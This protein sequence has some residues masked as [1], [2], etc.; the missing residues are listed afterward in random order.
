MKKVEQQI[1]NQAIEQR[2]QAGMS[3]MEVS[4]KLGIM[5]NVMYLFEAG[6]KQVTIDFISKLNE[7]FG[8]E[9]DVKISNN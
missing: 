4:I 7:V 1:I 6:K 5:Y 8:W 9:F 2:K 3:Q